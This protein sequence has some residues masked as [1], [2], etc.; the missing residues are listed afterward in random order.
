MFGT[1]ATLYL[2]LVL[3]VARL[4]TEY[5]A[6]PVARLALASSLFRGKYDG[7]CSRALGYQFAATLGDER[8]L[9]L[10]VALDYGARFDGQFG[11]VGYVHPSLEQIGPL[12]QCLFAGEDKFGI[13]IAYL[14]AVGILCIVGLAEQDVVARL[15]SAVSPPFVHHL[16]SRSG[17]RCGVVVTA[18]SGYTQ[19]KHSQCLHAKITYCF[20]IT[21]V[22]NETFVL[23]TFR[24]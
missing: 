11:P 23:F 18:A 2:H 7:F 1:R 20:H 8:S 22:Y 21:V 5:D 6:S 14:P 16:C 3:V 12:L 24:I 10:L 19:G 9:G 13:A 15:Q 17:I 4:A